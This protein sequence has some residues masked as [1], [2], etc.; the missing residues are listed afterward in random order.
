MSNIT[1][2]A[3]TTAPDWPVEVVDGF[4]LMNRWLLYTS[5]LLV[6]AQ[7]ISGIG[8]T[9]LTNTGF[10]AFNYYQQLKWYWATKARTLHALSLLPAHFNLIYAITYLGGI[11]S[12]NFVS[13][14]ILG[15]GSAGAIILNTISAW[16]S[17]KTNLPEGYGV[18][19]FFFFGWRTLSPQWRKFFLV[20]QIFDSMVA[21]CTTLTALSMSYQIAAKVDDEKWWIS[22]LKYPAIILGPVIMM[23]GV[24][25]LIM[26]TELIVQRN[27][28]VSPTDW[29]S[30]WLFIAQCGSM[31]IPS[32]RPIWKAISK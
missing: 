12:G 30:V 18:Y 20:W 16:E 21:A 5:L 26:W 22:Y 1:T 29:L 4:S 17:Y 7:F 25:P 8:G 27:N 6:P 32:I 23:L 9:G 3:N 19:R 15:F 28:I 24:W 14:T 31:L 11:S 10:L 13:A 2:V